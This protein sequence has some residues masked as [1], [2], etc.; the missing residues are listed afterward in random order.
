[1]KK[2]IVSILM[3]LGVITTV[4]PSDLYG[5]GLGCKKVYQYQSGAIINMLEIWI[6]EVGNKK[7]VCF[8]RLRSEYGVGMS[9]KEIK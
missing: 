9:C 2:F 5:F 6:C 1:M 8:V 4:F 3:I 7:Y